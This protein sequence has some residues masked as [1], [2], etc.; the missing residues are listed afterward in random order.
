M[1]RVAQG[2]FL[3]VIAAA[4]ISLNAGGL[5]ITRSE[6]WPSGTRTI[7]TLGEGIGIVFSPDLAPPG[8]CDFYERLG[9]ACFADP[10]WEIVTRRVAERSCRN[11]RRRLSLIILEVHGSG[12]NGLKLQDGNEA[13]SGR[14]Y[15]SL[16]ALQ[17]RFGAAGVRYC[18]IGACNSR[19]LSRERISRE[20]ALE[21]DRL[22]LPATLGVLNAKPASP[23]TPALTFIT[24]EESRF[25][26]L[27]QA[28]TNDLTRRVRAALGFAP[29]ARASFVVSDLLVQ[30]LIND[31]ALHLQQ[32][33]P[34]ETVNRQ[35][36][37]DAEGERLILLF[38][39]YL[40][41]LTPAVE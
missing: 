20:L 18:V 16:G 12:G 26:T 17:E 2:L 1:A 4:A 28:G 40:T 38:S 15:A 10:S 24:R 34:G 7:R 31:P 41:S 27:I 21:N 36:I 11:C 39:R 23:A 30:L 8:T 5:R 33:S 3:A 37:S 32:A 9:F 35:G 6:I 22:T 29:R 25:E 14:S 13:K 19:R